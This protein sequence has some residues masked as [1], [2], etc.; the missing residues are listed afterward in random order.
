MVAARVAIRRKRCGLYAGNEYSQQ[1]TFKYSLFGGRLIAGSEQSEIVNE[2]FLLRNAG[3]DWLRSMFRDAFV[4]R[5]AGD[6]K[7]D[8]QASRPVVVFLDGEYWG[9]YTL[10]ERYDE[11]YLQNHYG[12]TPGKAVI[13][14]QDGDLFR[15]DAGDEVNYSEMLRY[16]REN[17]LRG[18]TALQ[19][20]PDPNGCD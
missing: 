11:F 18:F 13:L 17:G 19:I 12:I 5:L 2:T 15:G 7:L 4:Q 16:I 8:T 3:Q 6:M 20:H 9:I 1:D 10:Q 14:R